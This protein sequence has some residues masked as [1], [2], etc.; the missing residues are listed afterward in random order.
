MS[1][2]ARSKDRRS[3]PSDDQHLTVPDRRNRRERS[4]GSK[5]RRPS[6][7]RGYHSERESRNHRHHSDDDAEGRSSRSHTKQQPSPPRAINTKVLKVKSD[8]GRRSS[9]PSTPVPL[10]SVR[11]SKVKPDNKRRPS[12]P[13]TPVSLPSVRADEQDLNTLEARRS[14]TPN[15]ASHGFQMSPP[16]L[17]RHLSASSPY[18]RFSE[19]TLAFRASP[20]TLDQA[21][22]NSFS[23][24]GHLY[25]VLP[26]RPAT[27]STFDT[28]TTADLRPG[29]GHRIMMTSMSGPLDSE[30]YQYDPLSSR[31]FRLVK[32]LSAS[33]SDIRCEIITQSLDAPH[34]Y[35]AISYA[36]G[37]PD[38]KADIIL[39]KNVLDR[40][41]SITRQRVTKSVTSNLHGAL[42]ALRHR[43]EDVFVWVDSLS[44]DQQNKDE[45]SGQVQLMSLIYGNAAAV[46]IWLGPRCNDSGKALRLMEELA[47]CATSPDRVH[48]RILDE[49]RRADFA[50]L[51]SL[52]E[53]EY[54]T[55][56]WVVQEVFI[57]D[58]SKIVV[59]CGKSR[60]PWTVYKTASGTLLDHKSEIERRYSGTRDHSGGQRVS[61]Q[62]YSFAQVLAYQ[63]PASLLDGTLRD[64]GDQPLLDV[65]RACRNKLTA[66]PLDKVYGILGLLSD[67]VRRDFPVNYK[68]SVK[69]VYIDVVDHILSTTQRV[70]VLRES[71]H[72]PM[73][74]GN[75]G[76]PSWC[77]DWSYIPAT[78][79]LQSTANFCASGST[80]NSWRFSDQRRKLEI[81]AIKLD[82]IDVHGVAV[83]TLTT[84]AD[85]LMAFLNWRTIMLDT[86]KKSLSHSLLDD[87]SRMLCLDQIPSEYRNNWSDVCH[88]V[89]ASLL[90]DRLPGLPLDSEL[91]RYADAA[92]LLQPEQ[93][94]QILQASFGAH[95]MGRSFCVTKQ[96]KY[97]CMG[98]GFMGVGDVIVVPLGCNTPIILR[99]EGPNE[100]RYVGDIYVHRY[101]YGEAVK[102]WKAGKKTL[103]KYVLH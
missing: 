83:G 102:Q 31:E 82:T 3:R 69:K 96:K 71:I 8:K 80:K 79:S 41:G 9:A 76:F 93:T 16:G 55:R 95:M 44:I 99:A 45:L 35:T 72:F 68:L 56:L 81:S 47:D 84:S 94:R 61:L 25:D 53:R 2:R 60:L 20:L 23:N 37:D 10:P 30:S 62:Q 33:M 32:I 28:F 87:F 6:L 88:H 26:L 29:N 46:A 15:I 22:L 101:M 19:D 66:M 85:Y 65:M 77:P 57:P 78:E 70:D 86:I 18:E 97:I 49:K 21:S 11:V 17:T 59:Y 89:F 38:D 7:D 75:T 73:H 52:F 12:A 92:G 34:D 91:K 4:E 5:R 64:L 39:E 36:W 13:S 54:W 43:D 50:A 63:G 74:V 58:P 90:R 40:Y 100:Y 1:D 51:V 48:R 98:S 42:F 14:S 103:H 67:K 27:A 24:S